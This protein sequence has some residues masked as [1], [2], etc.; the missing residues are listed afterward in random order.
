MDRGA[1]HEAP[2]RVWSFAAGL[3]A[4]LVVLAALAMPSVGIPIRV[5]LALAAVVGFGVSLRARRRPRAPAAWVELDGHGVARVEG[6]RRTTLLEWGEPSGVTILA[7]C[8]RTRVLVAFTSRSH[9]RYLRVRTTEATPE[10]F[11]WIGRH[12]VSVADGD[13]S[14]PDDEPELEGDAAVE[15]LERCIAED[16]RLMDRVYLTSARG[17]P[18]ELDGRR[19]TVGPRTIDLDGPLEWKASTFHESFGPLTTVYQATEIIQAHERIVLVAQMPGELSMG[20]D[21]ASAQRRD[22]ELRSVVMADLKLIQATPEPPPTGDSRVAIDRLFVVPLRR[23]LDRAP[24]G[25]RLG[26]PSE[27]P[28]PSRDA[29]RMR[30]HH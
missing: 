30:N 29:A 11:A 28:S 25:R 20:G 5:V 10:G 19:L 21:F 13:L 15:L 1:P 3:A 22:P 18:V 2:S 12:A 4:G 7:N 8:V 16:R 23:A 27:A 17:E 26:T 24:R 6:E 9:T 14:S